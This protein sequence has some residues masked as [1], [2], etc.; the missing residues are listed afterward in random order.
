MTIKEVEEALRRKHKIVINGYKHVSTMPLRA[1]L[2]KYI[3]EIALRTPTM[4][5]GGKVQCEAGRRRSLQDLYIICKQYYPEVTLKEVMLTLMDLVEAG[6]ITPGF[7][8][9]IKHEVFYSGFANF[10]RRL[11]HCFTNNRKEYGWSQKT[12]LNL[13]KK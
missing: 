3:T 13:R 4:K 8:S 10:P 7:C 5:T 2:R 11:E 6:V 9:Q 1:F 12:W